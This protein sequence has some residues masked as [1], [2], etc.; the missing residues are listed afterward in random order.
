MD[1]ERRGIKTTEALRVVRLGDALC[2]SV[3]ERQAHL[4]SRG[5]KG[6]RTSAAPP[7]AGDESASVAQVLVDTD[8]VLH[9]N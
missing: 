3:L 7:R 8:A 2:T 6:R 4:T 1:T 5:A 9:R